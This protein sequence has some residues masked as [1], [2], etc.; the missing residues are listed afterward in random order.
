MFHLVAVRRVSEVALVLGLY[1]RYS[2]ARD[3]IEERDLAYLKHAEQAH[4]I[5]PPQDE[6]SRQHRHD[7]AAFEQTA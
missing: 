7:E 3:A 1:F 4:E 6:E 5:H 2:H